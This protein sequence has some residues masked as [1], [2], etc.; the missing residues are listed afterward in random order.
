MRISTIHKVVGMKCDEV[1]L[2]LTLYINFADT[3]QEVL[4][5]LDHIKN[6][7]SKILGEDKQAMQKVDQ[8]TVKALESKAPRF[9]RLD[10]QAVQGPLLSGRIFSAF[11]QQDREAV[12]CRLCSIDGLIPSLFTFFE[13]IKYLQATADCVKQ[14]IKLSPR[15]T[16]FTALDNCFSNASQTSDQCIIQEADSTF[17]VR[18]GTSGDYF[19]LYYRQI[20]LGAMRKYP[21]V[22]VKR[23]KK[24]R[25]LLAKVGGGEA[26]ETVLC[27]I[28]ALA[29]RLGFESDEICALK[30]R[31]PD[32]EIARS[33][34]LKA[35]KP[36]RYEYDDTL[37]ESYISQIVEVFSTATPSRSEQL[38][39]VLVSDDP[40]ASGNRCGF[41][42]E[43]AQEE[44]SKL[45][46]IGNLHDAS[47]EQGEAIT[48][49]FVRRSVYFAF[50]G[51]STNLLTNVR[52]TAQQSG[53]SSQNS[54]LVRVPVGNVAMEGV[55]EEVEQ[56][57]SEREMQQERREQERREQERREQERREQERREQERREQ[58]RREQERLARL[59]Q[60]QLERERLARE[61]LERLEQERLARLEQERLAQ[62]RL[63][64]ERQARLEQE[65]LAKLKQERLE[66]ERLEQER[67]E[68]ERL[69]QER[70]ERERLEQERLEQERLKQERLE[71]ERLAR[72]E[73][74]RLARIE[75]ERLARIEQERLARIEQERLEQERLEQERLAR[76]EQER[77]A[78]LEQE[79][80]AKLEQERLEQLEQ[81]RLEHD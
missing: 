54:S 44:D 45:L 35:R 73:Q 41:P 57:I 66:Q 40:D 12:W 2:L 21:K 5:Y 63:E 58:E 64:Q 61:Q 7:W 46:F 78:R 75:Q 28:A 74:E 11:S 33:A 51:K 13:D 43:Q 23:K 48:S 67:L 18:P 62:E 56:G 52:S 22:P 8:A 76:I 17:A 39:P 77:L 59:E 69:E 49:F 6:V 20:W 3:Q 24:K 1:D 70:L 29:Y 25:D 81:E 15:D 42:D 34:L 4:H 50:F 38:T 80:L 36:D 32:R 68:Q 19:D 71:Q 26:D 31:S 30:Q 14:L 79:R 27:E 53:Y 16:V 37:F 10:A 9:S 72:I 55:V 47:E 65:R 60:E